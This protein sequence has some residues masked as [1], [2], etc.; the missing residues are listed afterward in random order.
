MLVSSG[1]IPHVSHNSG[2][3]EWYTPVQ[4]IES[5]RF[6]MGE[7]DLDPASSDLANQIVMARTYYTASDNGLVQKWTGRAF[8][9][10]PYSK[11]LIDLFC[12]KFAHE[13]LVGNMTEGIILVNN[14]TETA[15]FNTLTAVC[16]AVV[17][18]RRRI[19]FYGV[20][21]EKGSPLQGQAFLYF[22]PQT[23]RFVREFSQ[24]GWPALLR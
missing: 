2:N 13:A 23:Q 16:S 8:V 4:Y 15:W 20:N 9:N 10:P 1:A 14:A 18:P 21:G 19:K 11:R 12:S 6:V 22:G 5:A 7:I 3:N 17:F 24:Y